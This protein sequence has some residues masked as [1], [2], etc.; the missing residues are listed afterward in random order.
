MNI[1]LTIKGINSIDLDS[2]S[3]EEIKKHCKRL[4][5]VIKKIKK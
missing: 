4:L 2:L 1:D 3:K 5:V